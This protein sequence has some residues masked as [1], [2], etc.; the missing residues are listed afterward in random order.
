M[1]T[2]NNRLMIDPYDD[3]DPHHKLSGKRAF[4]PTKNRCLQQNF[5]MKTRNDPVCN[6]EIHAKKYI[7]EVVKVRPEVIRK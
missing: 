4:E 3:F 1:M 2:S 7:K 5:Q 6:Q